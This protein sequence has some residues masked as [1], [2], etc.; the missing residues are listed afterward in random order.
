[1]ILLQAVAVLYLSGPPDIEVAGYPSENPV[2][3]VWRDFQSA[4][5]SVALY[6]DG[7]TTG[8]VF[9]PGLLNPA[10]SSAVFDPG[11]GVL[12]V[13]SQYPS[14]ANYYLARFAVEPDF[15]LI[16]G[17]GHDAYIEALADMAD[18]LESGDY[19]GVL[20]RAWEVMY[21]ASNTCPAEMCTVLL[22]AGTAMADREMAAGRPPEEA[23]ELLED[24]Y[25]AG[26]NLSGGLLHDCA[27]NGYP[28]AS[29]VTREEYASSLDRLA[30]IMEA[31][32]EAETAAR[33]REAVFAL[34]SP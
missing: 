4:G 32:G 13:Y 31:A 15:A 17:E 27:L 16:S 30:E 14:T 6:A 1:M 8:Y 29:P 25:D 9:F 23:V 2:Y 33:I 26:F 7:D 18:A 20:F 10:K 34:E 12:T 3:V 19:S 28:G 24:F 5:T 21:P 11:T 22:A